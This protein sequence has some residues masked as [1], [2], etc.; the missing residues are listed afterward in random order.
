MAQQ[1]GQPFTVLDI[2]LA[3]RHGPHMLWVHQHDGVPILQQ[4]KY[5]LP[6]HARTLEGN[7]RDLL[8]I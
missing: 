1:I 6:K 8:A 3:S 2:G 7:V 4:I 5:W